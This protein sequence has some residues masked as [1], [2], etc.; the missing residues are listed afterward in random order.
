MLEV[1]SSGQ[2]VVT[3]YSASGCFD[4]DTIDVTAVPAPTISSSA[5]D[6]TCGG[7][8][9]G[10]I[11]MTVSGTVGPYNYAW[12]T[13][14]TTEDLSGLSQGIFIVTI[15]DNGGIIPCTY[16]EVVEINEPSPVT[17]NIDGT[18]TSCN[19]NDGT[20]QLSAYGGT[21]GY[22]YLLSLIHI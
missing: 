4:M 13:G 1:F 3:V 12:S 18:T 20:I 15:T 14:Q 17:A 7:Y 21:P 16:I 8:A 11:D 22:S 6:V 10:S 9:D 19:T 2:Y 5:L